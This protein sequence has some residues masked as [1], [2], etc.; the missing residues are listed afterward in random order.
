MVTMLQM[1][2]SVLSQ[3]FGVE[4]VG[5]VTLAMVALILYAKFNK[6]YETI[7]KKFV[8]KEKLNMIA[9]AVIMTTSAIVGPGL[10]IG[11]TGQVVA[12][13]TSVAAVVY[14]SFVLAFVVDD[15]IT[16]VTGLMSK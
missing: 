3:T 12:I 16:S 4:A 11:M 6:G 1:G 5:F 2:N 13:V 15:A 9:M 7:D 14:S 8:G 10:L